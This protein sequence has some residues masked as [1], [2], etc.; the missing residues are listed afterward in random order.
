MTGANS[1]QTVL[2]EPAQ[3][4]LI[5]IRHDTNMLL[6][7]RIARRQTQGIVHQPALRS[8]EDEARRVVAA[9]LLDKFPP[10]LIEKQRIPA[11]ID[12]TGAQDE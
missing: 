6:G 5:R 3:L 9:A 2:K 11:P 4:E 7:Q 12:W 8:R 1:E 10:D